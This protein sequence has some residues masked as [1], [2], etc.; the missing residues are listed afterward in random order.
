MKIFNSLLLLICFSGSIFSQ[1]LTYTYTFD[2]PDLE[3]AK[4]GYTNIVYPDCRNYGEEGNPAMPWKAIDLVL[5]QGAEMVEISVLETIYYKPLDNV[6]VVP[7]EKQFPLS[8]S[9][10][11]PYK[12]IPNQD[13]YNSA[14]PHP[15]VIT[16]EF[17]T[18]F[19]C[20]HSIGS[21]TICPVV[22]YPSQ[23]R[24]ECLREITIQINTTPTQ[25]ALVAGGNLKNSQ[26]VNNRIHMIVDNPQYLKTYN[27]TNAKNFS[28][29]D[30]LLISNNSL[31]LGFGSYIDFKMSTGYIVKPETVENI[32]SNY[33]GQDNQEKIRNCII[34]YYQNYG[35]SYVILGGDSD[36]STPSQLII[37]HRGF[38]ANAYNTPES[39][40]PADIYYS[41]LDGNWNNDGD[42]RWGEP[43]EDDLFSEVSIG[44]ICID[45]IGETQNFTNKLF[46][47]QDAPVVADI[48]KALMLG[49]LLW[50]DPTWG[51][52][53][54]DEVAYGSSNHGYTTTG[55]SPNFSITRL[56]EKLANWSKSDV[57]NQFNNQG[58]NLLNH[59]GHSSTNYNMLMYNS[60][61]TTS[62][63]Q[64]DGV[65]RGYVIGYSQ[66]CYNGSF[67]N[68]VSSGSYLSED[69]FNEKLTTLQTGMV[70]AIG[71][72]RYG[73]GMH[74]STDGASQYF[75]RQFYD[76][77][78]GEHITIIGDANADSKEDNV[79]YISSHSGAIRWCFYEVNLF[80]DPTMD[81]WTAVPSDI[82]PTYPASVPLGISQ[83]SFQ[84]SIPNARI[85]VM[86]NGVLLGRALTDPFGTAIVT[87]FDPISQVVN[88]DI[89]I[90]AHNRN[91][92]QGTI[93]VISNEPY[94]VYSPHQ[95]NAINGNNNG[96]AEY[97][98]TILLDI[99]LTNVGNVGATGVN[100]VLSTTDPYITITDNS[101]FYG[102]FTPGEII[103]INDAFAFDVAD[104]CPDNHLI[105]FNLEV[106]GQSTWSSQF[107]II[108]HAPVLEA[109]SVTIDDVTGGNGNGMLDP[110]ESADI[111]ITTSNTGSSASQDCFGS[112]STISTWATIVTG[113]CNM[114][115]I[116]AGTSA[117]AF[118]QITV[119][120]AA[121]IGAVVE[122]NYQ[123]TAGN[124]NVSKTYIE[125]VGLILEDWET[126]N[127]S[128]F[129]WETSSSS[130]W[131]VVTDNPYEGIYCAKSGN[132]G[133]NQSTTLMILCN[134][135]ASGSI[136][137][138]RK[139]SSEA[140]YDFL[141]FYIDG[142]EVGSWSG[143][144]NWSEVN[145]P[146]TAGVHSF[147]W[148][149]TK[150]Q[151]VAN[152][153]DCGWIDYI[154]FPPVTE[155]AAMAVPYFTDF[156]E[157]GSLPGGWY[158]SAADDIDWIANSGSTPSNNTGPSGDH[159]TGSGYY[160]YVEASNPNYPNK[161]AYLIS[162]VFDFTTLID[163]QLSFWY[164]MNGAAMGDLH[165]DAYSNGSWV[166]DIMPVISGN[167]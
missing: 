94:V 44:R 117:D 77:V 22:Y 66:G 19:L 35:I 134:V 85:A 151:A 79:G 137:F 26:I 104:P 95:L 166:N 13:V 56:Y 5:P 50:N 99:E 161:H 155:M 90:I 1:T 67:D 69:C 83:I 150:D 135:S 160:L 124:Y 116:N 126:G 6:V 163:A 28:E 74:N 4:D 36:P 61:L 46:M 139:V 75:D 52:D 125:T 122:L 106:T 109:G 81:I 97:G 16:G 39:D 107:N 123:A 120:A 51:G 72:S 12:V 93:V 129:D 29:Y 130:G 48:E 70:A 154:I 103:Q 57:F 140:T 165:V 98:E 78:F 80:G 167:Q 147:Q 133:D 62:N 87:L 37:P 3:Q 60:D 24:I 101:E 88:L 118:F 96:M 84:T 38:Y 18:N 131:T 156:E 121:P 162:P 41:N 115:I 86:Q 102:D 45:A 31:L 136:S 58:V 64:N 43:G 114:G 27:Y 42:N 152:G 144:V 153:S 141:R 63:F 21:F 112:L 7:A 92:H 146:V 119:D 82:I 128:K 59:L 91:R 149:Y 53:Y 49:E 143:N 34:D 47:Y 17:L 157:S 71:N 9:M 100:A 142:N 105:I 73:W 15:G 111:Y 14:Q 30:I 159:T 164:H 113:N 138:F 25:R 158:N 145:Y 10:D 76:A 40:I 65:T 11:E 2:L 23:S 20:G 148:T 32:Y 55:V 8:I 33:A 127:M 132:I 89:S 110:G 108:L 54:K 68:R